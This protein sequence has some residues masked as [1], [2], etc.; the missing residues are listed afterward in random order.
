MSTFTVFHTYTPTDGVTNTNLNGNIS[1]L[2]TAGNS[3]DRTNLLGGTGIDAS[4]VKPTGPS[5]A[6]FGGTQPYTFPTE[7][8][9]TGTSITT[10]A[11]AIGGDS[12]AT[13]GMLLNVP[14]SSTNGIQLQV[15]GVTKAQLEAGGD[16]MVAPLINAT[17]TLGRV[18]PG[19]TAAGVALASTWHYVTGVTGSVGASGST[20]IT[21]TNNAV[22]TSITSYSVTFSYTDAKA[23]NTIGGTQNVSATQFTIKNLD[24][25]N[26][27]T[28]SWVASGT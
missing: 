24:A 26:A 14:T 8:D 2:V 1:A 5:A 28:F 25:A 6:T 18:P 3:I 9:F 15:N 22:F 21:L 7:V 12:G 17:S 16:F 4:S 11:V 13:Q 20:T 10:T 19:Y 27:H 23:I